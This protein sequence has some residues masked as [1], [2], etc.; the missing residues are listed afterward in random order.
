MPEQ[1][2]EKRYKCRVEENLRTVQEA[3]SCR[4]FDK[5]KCMI[6]RHICSVVEYS[7]Q[8]QQPLSAQSLPKSIEIVVDFKAN[9]DAQE[10]AKRTERYERI[11]HMADHLSPQ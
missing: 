4:Y 2:I 3:Q 8:D 7:L 1:K 9:I 6:Y 11:A 10:Q 5:T